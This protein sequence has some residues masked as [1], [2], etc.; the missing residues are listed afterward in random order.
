M[1]LNNRDI[2]L[3]Y[4]KDKFKNKKYGDDNYLVHLLDVENIVVGLY[5]NY[6]RIEF[7]ILAAL[8]HDLLEDTNSTEKELSLMISLDIVDLI[9][10]LTDKDGEN[11]KERHLKTYPYIR[12]NEEAVIIK[13]ADR[14]SNIK[15]AIK[16][17]NKSKLSMYKKEYDTFK[18]ALY[19]DRHSLA[20]KAWNVYDNLKLNI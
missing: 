10:R 7:L 1:N 14:I 8:G 18:Y 16:T 9:K 2:F 6:L 11:R 4:C 3:S 13:I 5:S 17:K 15:N 20:K 12:E 19:D